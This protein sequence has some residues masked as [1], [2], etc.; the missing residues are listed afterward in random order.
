M[1][2]F[3]TKQK[4]LNNEEKFT[5]TP[6]LKSPFILPEDVIHLGEIA[7]KYNSVLKIGAN[8]KISIINIKKEKRINTKYN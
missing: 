4:N 2:K 5:I 1:D 6:N 3:I 8:Q 7:Q